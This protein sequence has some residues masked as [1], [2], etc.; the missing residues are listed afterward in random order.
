MP[1]ESIISA[2]FLHELD[3]EAQATRK[4]LERVPADLFTWKPHDKSM[5]LGYLALIVAEIPKWVQ[6]MVE[7]NDIDF[8]GDDDAIEN[9]VGFW[10]GETERLLDFTPPPVQNFGY[11]N[12]LGER[13][14]DL[15][16][17]HKLSVN[18]SASAP[19]ALSLQS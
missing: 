14:Y 12:R 5:P 17:S 2:Q 16:E 1:G 7:K 9:V 11:K 15:T 19:L 8:V 10:V 13:L 4:C 6:W 3:S 18:I